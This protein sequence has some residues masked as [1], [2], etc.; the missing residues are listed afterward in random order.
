MEGRKDGREEGRK[1]GRKK[2]LKKNKSRKAG[3]KDGRKEGRQ[4][5]GRKSHRKMFNTP[6]EIVQ[7]P[8][9]NFSTL[10]LT[11]FNTPKPNWIRPKSDWIRPKPDWIQPY[12]TN[13][14]Y[15]P[16]FDWIRPLPP[17]KA[18]NRRHW[19][20][21]SVQAVSWKTYATISA[22]STK[23]QPNQNIKTATS[24]H[25]DKGKYV[26]KHDIICS[27]VVY[28]VFKSEELFRFLWLNWTS[29]V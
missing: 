26:E 12:M 8:H 6:I 21:T 22:N 13:L 17:P 25:K 9:W 23:P 19:G 18:L 29:Y 7:H 27:S 24:P 15:A 5:E 14:W 20:F 28:H 11:F 10:A 2:T 3:R 16:Q 4:K 1:R